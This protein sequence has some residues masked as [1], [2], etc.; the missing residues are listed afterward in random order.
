MPSLSKAQIH[1]YFV[2]LAYVI[3]AYFFTAIDDFSLDVER[4]V[5]GGSAGQVDGSDEGVAEGGYP[6]PTAEELNVELV[7]GKTPV[8]KC[9]SLAT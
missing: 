3:N 1:K 9:G 7:Q 4:D 5:A 2:L 8:H 6:T